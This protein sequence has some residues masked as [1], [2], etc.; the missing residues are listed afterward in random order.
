MVL[1]VVIG[2]FLM[3]IWF[4]MMFFLPSSS[5]GKNW[6][7]KRDIYKRLLQHKPRQTQNLWIG[8]VGAKCQPETNDAVDRFKIFKVGSPLG[9]F[10]AVTMLIAMPV[11]M[12]TLYM[13][14]TYRLLMPTG[15][16]FDDVSKVAQVMNEA[17]LVPPPALP[18]SLFAVSKEQLFESADRDW[19]KL[20]AGFMQQML[21]LIVGMKLYGYEMVLL[22]GYRSPER[23]DMLADRG[24]NITRA[25]A[26][27]SKHQ[28]GLAV[29]MA[30]MR[31]GKLVIAE[32]DPWAMEGY[33]RLGM[34]AR[35]AGLVWGGGW[36]LQDYGHIE[37]PVSVKQL[38]VHKQK[39]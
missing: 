9:R 38:A 11:L 8:F 34:L 18:P 29:D 27:Q 10:V 14:G 3:L 22:E 19:Q 25:G 6:I 15:L 31:D 28:Y 24:A 33:Q 20:D 35:Q 13:S 37:S 17:A 12:G 39:N 5:S 1:C 4:G 16:N 30:F 23:Q 26:Y 36:S 7:F 21:H 32:T 2:I